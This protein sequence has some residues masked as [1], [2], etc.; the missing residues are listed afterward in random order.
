MGM[1]LSK[2]REFVMDREVWCA[3]IHDWATELNWTE[4]RG[5][6]DT[7]AGFPLERPCDNMLYMGSSGV[8]D[9]YYVE[10]LKNSLLNWLAV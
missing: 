8:F 6:L 7:T 4:L 1:S 5:P 10:A 2:L 3:A 9:A